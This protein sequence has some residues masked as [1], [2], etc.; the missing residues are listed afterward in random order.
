VLGAG[1]VVVVDVVVEVGSVVCAGVVTR[2][3]GTDTT[4]VV[5][6]LFLPALP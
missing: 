4:V 1:R 6:V 2:P 5:V 3:A